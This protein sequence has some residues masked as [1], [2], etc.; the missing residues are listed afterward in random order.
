MLGSTPIRPSLIPNQ[1]CQGE[2]TAGEARLHVH[3][4]TNR[5]GQSLVS[6]QPDA[7]VSWKTAH[8]AKAE[9][10]LRTFLLCCHILAKTA[11]R[12]TKRGGTGPCSF[13]LQDENNLNEASQA[14]R[15]S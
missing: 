9:V 6:G 2:S 1:G 12:S 11:A 15:P 5:R 3:A 4:H 7:H 10:K 8:Q 13:S 14:E